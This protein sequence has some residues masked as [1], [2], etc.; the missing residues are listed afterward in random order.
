[1]SQAGLHGFGRVFSGGG[2]HVGDCF[3][4]VGAG[5]TA[6]DGDGPGADDDTAV[7]EALGEEGKGVVFV[8]AGAAG[9]GE[10]LAAEQAR[11][12]VVHGVE[13]PQDFRDA[14]EVDTAVFGG[15]AEEAERAINVGRI[16]KRDGAEQVV[17]ETG[18]LGE[19]G[20]NFAELG[21]GRVVTPRSAG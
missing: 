19:G 13:L 7:A 15:H 3:S 5:E 17:D 2:N 14:A 9:D 8:G 4:M 1:M 21:G 11:E 18:T 6:E 12:P 16:E 10:E 20:V